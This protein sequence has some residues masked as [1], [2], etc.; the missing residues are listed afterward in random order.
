MFVQSQ[1]PKTESTRNIS[2]FKQLMRSITY[3]RGQFSLI[4]ACCNHPL[5]RQ[6]ISQQLHQ[7]C[8]FHV[9]EIFLE[10]SATTLYSTIQT[11]LGTEHPEAL[12]VYG[13]ESVEA[14]NQLLIAT[15]TVRD[16]FRKFDFP[17]VL[18][19]TDEILK[20]LIR[21]APHSFSWASIGI[22]FEAV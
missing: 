12:M 19:V 10:R 11:E 3:S 8:Q 5:M 18:W 4:L 22:K 20:K 2:A 16:E 17:L 6:E 21:I 1:R 13:L 14:L 7:Q 9:R 15:D